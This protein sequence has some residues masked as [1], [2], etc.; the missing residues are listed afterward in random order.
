MALIALVAGMA[1]VAGSW[2]MISGWRRQPAPPPRPAL[3]V[4]LP[5][6]RILATAGAGL[7]GLVVTRWPVAGA[8]V[9]AAAWLVGGWW[10]DRGVPSAE[11]KAEALALWV[12]MLRDTVGT[13][14]GL[15]G[16]IAVTASTAP[17]LIRPE[18]MRVAARLGD[19]VA[20]ERVLDEL[21]VALDHPVSDLV[22]VALA[23]TARSGGAK[24]VEVLD[25]LAAAAHGEAEVH[26][27]L[28]VARSRPRATM[29]YVA[30]AIALTVVALIVF[31]GDYLAPYGS[32]QGQLVL[33]VIGAVFVAAFV[34][35]D[36]LGR[37]Q[38]IDRF[39]RPRP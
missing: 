4:R 33:V 25:D 1:I 20:L 8:A 13:A 19:S 31:G 12:E 21:G 9:A 37:V 11:K 5:I 39:L 38:D 3:W 35:M 15:E 23:N 6:V 34:W 10:A 36:R 32:V 14:K 30:V 26:R 27:R 17:P 29:R 28:E 7:A 2:L 16:V 22:V 18:V 24:L